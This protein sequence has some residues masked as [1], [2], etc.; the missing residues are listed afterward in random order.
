MLHRQA[1]RRTQN[2]WGPTQGF[3]VGLTI[4]VLPALHFRRARE[5]IDGSLSVQPDK[6]QFPSSSSL[7]STLSPSHCLPF[8]P[9]QISLMNLSTCRTTHR[10]ATSNHHRRHVYPPSPVEESKN[11]GVCTQLCFKANRCGN[12]KITDSREVSKKREKWIKSTCGPCSAYPCP[13]PSA[14]KWNEL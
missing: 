2:Y 6:K 14:V 13:D 3:A 8:P 7:P 9:S 1:A 4:N 12:S 5:L 11:F 10:Q